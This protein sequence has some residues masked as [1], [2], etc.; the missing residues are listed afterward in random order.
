MQGMTRPDV[1]IL[2][3]GA[4]VPPTNVISPAPN[5]FTHE[6]VRTQPFFF[7]ENPSEMPPNGQFEEGTRV[8]LLFHDGS[9]MCRVADAKGLYVLTAY[10]GL[11]KMEK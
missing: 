7:R 10:G 1:I 9:T 4:V 2:P 5:Q 3:E 11:R 8:N 6:L